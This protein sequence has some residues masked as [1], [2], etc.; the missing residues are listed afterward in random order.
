VRRGSGDGP[1]RRAI[2]YDVVMVLVVDGNNVLH[3]PMPARWD[4]LGAQGLCRLIDVGWRGGR[5]SRRAVVVCDGH[6]GPLDEVESPVAGVEL[7]WSG[8]GRSADD[9]IVALVEG[10]AHRRDATV[11]TTDRE[12][13]DRL[14]SLGATLQRSD[15]FIAELDAAT[16]LASSD[17]AA[18]A[19]DKPRGGL[20]P[21][22]TEDWLRR[23]GLGD[24]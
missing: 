14:R 23:F 4:G 6:P 7:V 20:D 18:A 15:A 16:R 5:A 3:S 13:R 1:P 8:R 24:R 19:E 21:R 2:P 17:H 22:E 11:V 12:L 9:V 10:L